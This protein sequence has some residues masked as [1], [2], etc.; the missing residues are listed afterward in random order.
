MPRQVP[1]NTKEKEVKTDPPTGQKYIPVLALEIFSEFNIFVGIL[2]LILAFIISVL[3]NGIF[4]FTPPSP[5]F[6]RDFHEEILINSSIVYEWSAWNQ[7]FTVDLFFENPSL[8]SNTILHLET[9]A[10]YADN[11]TA[12]FGV[13]QVQLNQTKVQ[14]NKFISTKDR[15][16]ILCGK[17]ISN[18]FEV[19]ALKFDLNFAGQFPTK[20]LL[21][22]QLSWISA[23]LLATLC[24]CAFASIFQLVRGFYYLVRETSRLNTDYAQKQ[25]SVVWALTQLVYYIPFNSPFYI[26]ILW[27]ISAEWK[28][29]SANVWASICVIEGWF[30]GI[31][32]LYFLRQRIPSSDDNALKSCEFNRTW[33]VAI[34]TYFLFATYIWMMYDQINYSDASE[35]MISKGFFIAAFWLMIAQGFYISIA[36]YI[37]LRKLPYIPYRPLQLAFR[38]GVVLQFFHWLVLIINFGL[39]FHEGFEAF[40]LP[41]DFLGFG[42]PIIATAVTCL[43]AEGQHPADLDKYLAMSSNSLFD[44]KEAFY[45]IEF[46]EQIYLE[47]PALATKEQ[48]DADN[49]I[50]QNANSLSNA[51]PEVLKNCQISKNGQPVQRFMACASFGWDLL[52]FFHDSKSDTVAAIFY[53]PNAKRVVVSF[54]GTSSVDNAITDIKLR[55]GFFIF[56]NHNSANLSATAPSFLLLHEGF[57]NAYLTIQKDVT[58]AAAHALTH[59]SATTIYVTGHSLGGALASLFSFDFKLQYPLFEIV[60]YTFGQPQVGNFRYAQEYNR[61][62]PKT[63]RVVNDA[64]LVTRAYRLLVHHNHEVVIDKQ[65]NVLEL[66]TFLERVFLTS[67]ALGLSAHFLSSYRES[68]LNC[69]KKNELLKNFKP[70]QQNEDPSQHYLFA[71]P[72]NEVGGAPVRV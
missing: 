41:M 64:D 70:L 55:Y 53:D 48:I 10:V 58:I 13:F 63:F 2:I 7:D 50:H 39:M 40:L 15:C 52:N 57:R 56:R 43:F 33:L 11:T 69:E 8:V 42:S 12:S 20:I 26:F 72:S 29:V 1:K 66:A 67:P 61:L 4:R 60:C 59:F 3:V 45:F 54:R 9:F 30:T 36:T 31:A 16:K 32:S 62:V 5:T 22:K 47:N 25:P 14:W 18:L 46:A 44:L 27:D 38:F 34:P 6:L 37:D 21:T 19:V 17:N 23:Y 49:W 24:A 68:L 28:F 71:A 51:P 35:F 65:G